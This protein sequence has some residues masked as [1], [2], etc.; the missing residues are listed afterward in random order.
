VDQLA[1]PVPLVAADRDFGGPVQVR[2]PGAAVAAQDLV[3]GRGI[4]AQL[5]GGRGVASAATRGGR[6]Y[7]RVAS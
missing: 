5:P 2:Q 1:G 6:H 4:Q 7:S 3:H